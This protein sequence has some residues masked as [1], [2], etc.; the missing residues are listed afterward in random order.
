MQFRYEA[1]SAFGGS[2]AAGDNAFYMGDAS[3]KVSKISTRATG[4]LEWIYRLPQS[5][6]A[7]PLVDVTNGL[8]YVSTEAGEL[9]AIEDSTGYPAWNQIVYGTARIQAPV[10]ICNGSVICRTFSRSLAAY[11]IRSGQLLGQSEPGPL[12][13]LIL[14]NSMTDRLYVLGVRGELSCYRP[15]GRMLPKISAAYDGSEIAKPGDRGSSSETA[16]ARSTS[17]NWDDFDSS[18]SDTSSDP[19]EIS[20]DMDPFSEAENPFDDNGF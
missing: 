18:D 11:D 10:A 16:P 6:T 9:T 1:G 17:D 12:S 19:F 13:D 7:K 5:I 8:V 15:I 14:T 2:L 4:S 20:D 3:G